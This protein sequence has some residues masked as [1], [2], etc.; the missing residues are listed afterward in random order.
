[1]RDSEINREQR[2][3]KAS[4]DMQYRRIISNLAEGGVRRVGEAFRALARVQKGTGK[5]FPSNE[6]LCEA[7]VSSVSPHDPFY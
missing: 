5:A 6:G 3:K 1:M 4:P 2:R 7:K